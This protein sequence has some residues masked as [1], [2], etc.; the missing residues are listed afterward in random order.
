MLG[1][2]LLLPNVIMQEVSK[3][4]KF[5]RGKEKKEKDK[6]QRAGGGKENDHYRGPR[7][8]KEDTC[9]T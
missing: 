5:I 2:V 7:Q 1:Y 4:R 6:K 3:R 9:V 8:E